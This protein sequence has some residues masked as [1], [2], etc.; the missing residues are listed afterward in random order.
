MAARRL[1]RLLTEKELDREL[2]LQLFDRAEMLEK[3]SSTCGEAKVLITYTNESSTRTMTSSQMAMLKLGG[4]Y[5]HIPAQG[6]SEEKDECFEDTAVTLATIGA[7]ILAVR[8]KDEEAI[9]AAAAAVAKLSPVPFVNCG[10]S[11]I[12]HPTQAVADLYMLKRVFGDIGGLKIA[13]IG[14]IDNSRA[15]NSFLYLLTEW[16]GITVYIV[17]SDGRRLKGSLE[18]FLED[19]KDRVR[20]IETSDLDE[21]LPLVDLVYQSRIQWNH[22]PDPEAARKEI[23]P[24]VLNRKNVSRMQK[25]AIILHPW[26]RNKELLREVDFLPQQRYIKLMKYATY[27]RMALFANM[28]GE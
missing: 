12:H 13:V 15:V 25:H 24:H 10:S 2:M 11:G 17:T 21:V 20:V 18:L 16:T 14:G 7:D 1:T 26:P 3:I 27:M 22:S 5:I 28:L 9:F 6:S 4:Q 23:P 8:H 19:R